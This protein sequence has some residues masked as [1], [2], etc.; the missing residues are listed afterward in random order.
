MG[1][2]KFTAARWLALGLLCDQ[3]PGEPC[4]QCGPCHR[5]QAGTHPDLFEVD[6]RAHGLDALGVA[7][8][9]PRRETR[10]SG[11]TGPSVAEFLSLRSAEG[12]ARVVLVREAERMNLSAQNA[13][14]KTLEEPAAGT[15]LVMESSQPGVLLPTIL[16]RVVVVPVPAPSL[17]QATEVLA[18]LQA[19]Q[20]KGKSKVRPWE[21]D[22]LA[23]LVRM[24]QGSPGL[25]WRYG[26]QERLAMRGVLVGVL[27]GTMGAVE[28]R[29]R[30]MELPGTFEGKTP[31]A[32]A[33]ERAAC[34][35]DL[36][37]QL[38]QDT[39]R[40]LAGVP[41]DA[42]AHGAYLDESMAQPVSFRRAATQR[43][44][45]VRADVALNLGAESLLDRALLALTPAPIPAFKGHAS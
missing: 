37:L 20:A 4:L 34:V 44:L 22:A 29:R 32:E 2:G 13:F 40:A 42:L 10:S 45:D 36:A 23:E 24:A 38:L 15:I 6:A 14:L 17:E 9:A 33:R 21:P 12:G 31:T 19:A 8:F 7:F 43:L 11:Y 39:E 25:A 1:V 27:A 18:G 16:S 5:A 30:L 26:L 28:A 3:G 41:L 35:L